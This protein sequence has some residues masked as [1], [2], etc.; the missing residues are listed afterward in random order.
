MYFD[1]LQW[2]SEEFPI[3]PNTIPYFVKVKP[4]S[5]WDYLKIRSLNQI[6]HC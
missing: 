4:L 5:H 2:G 1:S 3:L 6:F